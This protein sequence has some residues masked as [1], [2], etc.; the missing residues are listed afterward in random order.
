GVVFAVLGG[1]LQV[2][3]DVVR[4]QFLDVL[5]V[6]ECQVIA[7]SG[8][9]GHALDAGDAARLAV[10]LGGVLVVGLQMLADRGV[11]ARQTT[12]ALLDGFG[13]AVQAIHVGGGAAEVGDGT[14]ET[15]HLVADAFDLAQDGLFGAALDDAAFV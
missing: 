15:W 3:A 11:Y 9:D 10:E 5:G 8:G 6:L 13:L 2:A 1:N 12:A 7:Q 14:G 4:D